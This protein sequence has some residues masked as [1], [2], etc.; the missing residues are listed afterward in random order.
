MLEDVSAAT[1]RAQQDQF[2]D[3]HNRIQILNH[4]I[5]SMQDALD[6]FISTSS[7]RHN[8]IMNRLVPVD[9]RSSAALRNVEKVERTSMQILRDLESKDF[10][11]MMKQIHIALE[12]NAEGVVRSLPGVIRGHGPSLTTFLFVAVAVQIMVVGAYLVWKKRRGGA[13]KYL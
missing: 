2:A 5:V 3:L 12:N 7:Q 13:K 6:A 10:K 9:D 8:D 11:D 4:R 1:I